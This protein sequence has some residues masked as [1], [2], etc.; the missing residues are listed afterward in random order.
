MYWIYNASTIDLTELY[1]Q[2]FVVGAYADNVRRSFE[3]LEKASNSIQN[4]IVDD[5]HIG[6]VFS[7]MID[8]VTKQLLGRLK[9]F[10]PGSRPGLSRA[11]SRSPVPGRSPMLRPTNGVPT[12]HPHSGLE[13]YSGNGNGL[14]TPA[15]NGD[16]FFDWQND[17]SSLINNLE[18]YDSSNPTN[19]TVMPPPNFFSGQFD[20]GADDGSDAM[21]N[22][23]P[24]MNSNMP[25]WVAMEMDPLV[26]LATNGQNNEVSNTHF[27]PQI[28]GLDM[29]DHFRFSEPSMYEQTPHG[30]PMVQSNGHRMWGRP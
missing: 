28:N 3:L 18:V 15:L 17:P 24:F 16:G 23:G 6:G 20:T 29:L 30:L 1:D 10:P 19:M 9:R 13:S 11:Q 27:G 5:V 2:T 22:G 8:K 7:E 21:G 26:N 14:N 4:N 12:S 25:E